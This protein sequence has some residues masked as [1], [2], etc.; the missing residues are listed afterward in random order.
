LEALKYS[1]PAFEPYERS[2]Y[3]NLN[4]VVLG[5]VLSRVTNLSSAQA[6]EEHILNVV[7]MP[8]TYFKKPS[9][10]IGAIPVANNAWRDNYGPT[11]APYVIRWSRLPLSDIADTSNSSHGMFSSTNDLTKLVRGILSHR[12][13]TPVQTH[14]WLK[15][16]S[17]MAEIHSSYGMPWEIQRIDTLSADGHTIDI[18]KKGGGCAA[19]GSHILLIPE[20]DLGITILTAGDH[21]AAVASLVE[22]MLTITLPEL[23]RIQIEQARDEYSGYFKASELKSSMTLEVSAKTGV[24]ITEWISN[25]TDFVNV[26]KKVQNV[27]SGGGEHGQLMLRPTGMRHEDGGGE[28]WMV[29]FQKE[30]KR[31]YVGDDYCLQDI[32]GE[33]YGEHSLGEVLMYREGSK[34]AGLH[35]GA[36]RVDLKRVEVGRQGVEGEGGERDANR[37]GNSPKKWQT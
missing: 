16:R 11:S 32:L 12:L 15:P 2:T 28:L 36:L 20:Y 24:T 35:L 4:F 37:M 26:Y 27:I 8:N 34:V 9:D 30:K 13:L 5:E 31:K 25:G 33:P 10:S 14:A 23:E 17:F 3:S 1:T 21:L 19:Y 29:F 7:D 6:V 22:I 18:Y